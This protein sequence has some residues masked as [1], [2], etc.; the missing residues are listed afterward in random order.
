MTGCCRGV[1]GFATWG[2]AF[3]RDGGGAMTT[4]GFAKVFSSF[5]ANDATN[6][7]SCC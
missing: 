4:G 3:V 6:S 7:A 5:N 1:H 2:A